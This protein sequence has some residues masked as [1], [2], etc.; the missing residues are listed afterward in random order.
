VAATA[1]VDNDFLNALVQQLE[2]S[3]CV[4]T[5]RVGLTG[6]SIGAVMDYHMLCADTP[7]LDS[8]APV[9]GTMTTWPRY[10]GQNHPTPLLAINGMLDPVVPYEGH[11]PYWLSVPTDIGWMAQIVSCGAPSS[12]AQ[13]DITTTVMAGCNDGA[14]VDLYTV[15]D[16]GHQWPGGITLPGLGYCSPYLDAS[17]VILQFVQDH[18]GA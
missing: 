12:T 1:T 2:G 8:V 14:E 18:P 17:T 6:L 11:P 3:L 13:D 5:S 9:A 7:W 10:C 16:G 15:S 4:D